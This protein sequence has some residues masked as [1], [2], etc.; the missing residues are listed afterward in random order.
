M[1]KLYSI[2]VAFCALAITSCKKST[3][4]DSQTTV[5]LNKEVVFADSTYTMNYLSGLYV[6]F[7]LGYT[8]LSDNSGY[9]YAKSASRH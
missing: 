2:F 4:L 8:M 1:N 6:N 5:E 7:S 3:F 9:D